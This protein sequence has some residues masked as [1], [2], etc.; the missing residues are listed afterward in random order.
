[1]TLSAWLATT[2]G[3]ADGDF[4]GIARIDIGAH[5]VPYDPDGDADDDGAS[6]YEE[7][8]WGSNPLDPNDLPAW[9]YG[10]IRGGW[11]AILR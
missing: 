8:L 11:R 6:N 1:M 9:R 5:E 7:Y 2:L 10:P 3:R 4:N